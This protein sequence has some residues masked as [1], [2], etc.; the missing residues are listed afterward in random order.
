MREGR[1][2]PEITAILPPEV[3]QAGLSEQR[4]ARATAFGK[5]SSRKAVRSSRALEAGSPLRNQQREKSVFR[6]PD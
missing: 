1:T 3:N 5:N 6:R 2:S 4:T